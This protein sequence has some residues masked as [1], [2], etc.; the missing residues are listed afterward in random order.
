MVDKEEKEQGLTVKKE[1]DFSEWYTQVVIKSDLADYS[2]VSGCMVLKPLGYAVWEKIRAEVDKRLKKLGIKNAYF[3]LFIPESLLAR[4]AKHVEGFSPE[5]AWV[6][7]GGNTKLGERLAIRPTSEA[8]MYDSYSRWIRSWRDLPLRLNQWNNAVRWEFKHPVLLL[9][10]REFLWN[11]GHTAFATKEEAEKEI[12][13]I[14]SIYR[15]VCENCLALYGVT[16]RKTEKEKFAGAEY[17]CSIEYIMPNGRGVQGP[18]AHFDGQNFS[19]AYDIKFTDKEGKER[20]VWQNTWAITT[21]MIG[22]MAAVHSDNKGLVLPPK[23]APVQA[24]IVPII[25]E[26]DKVKILKK[27]KEIKNRL[28]KKFAVELDERDEYTPGWKFN[29]WELKGVPLRIELGPKDMAKKQVMLVRRDTSRKEAVKIASLNKKISSA[30]QEM[31]ANLLKKSRKLLESSIAQPKT[32]AEALRAINNKK[33]VLM[34]FCGETGCEDWIK[35]KTN[36]ASTRCI[37]F[38]QP[39]YLKTK[40]L[41][42]N[43]QAKFMTYFAKA[44]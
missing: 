1:D 8:I 34:P 16:G 37:P 5:V 24:V 25:F 40:C 2:A 18:D 44:Y 21:R 14:L 39:K 13:E 17:T 9:R 11:E 15:D 43:K 27:A 32:W 35:D 12:M 4:E 20:Y 30:L 33:L 26:K 36:G 28:S 31:Q 7:Y 42:C 3:P 10:T 23:L 29:E 38:N 41:H 19:R 6:T 22:V